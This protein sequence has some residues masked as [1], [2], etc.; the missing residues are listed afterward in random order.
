MTDALSQIGGKIDVRKD[1][2]IKCASGLSRD[3]AHFFYSNGDNLSGP[4]EESTLRH[5][6]CFKTLFSVMSIKVK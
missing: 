1:E 3:D 6:S 4:G 5:F 2:E